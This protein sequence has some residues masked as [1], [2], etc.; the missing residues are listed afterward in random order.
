MSIEINGCVFKIHPVYN[1]YAGCDNGLIV[2][3]NKKIYKN[4]YKSVHNK[5]CQ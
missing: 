2:C 5:I 3:I 4:H 1:L